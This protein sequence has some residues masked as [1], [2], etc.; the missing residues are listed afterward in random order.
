MQRFLAMF[1]LELK[2]ILLVPIVLIFGIFFPPFMFVFQ[3]ENLKK[4]SNSHFDP[5]TLIPMLTM[6]TIVILCLTSLPIALASDRQSKYFKRLYLAGVSPKQ[7]M[8]VHYVTQLFLGLFTMALLTV[9]AKVHYNV[10]IPYKYLPKFILILLL[11]HMMLYCI[12]VVI[13]NTS[14]DVKTVQTRALVIYFVFLFLG[15]LTYPISTMPDKFQKIAWCLPTTY[16]VELLKN[17]L[18]GKSLLANSFIFVVLGI[19][20]VASAGAFRIFRWE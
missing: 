11:L 14:S 17:I 16:G 20:V 2:K 12:G 18:A 15:D 9:I 19:L 5:L 3:M 10:N 6:L 1:T 13:G 8:L 7:Y 4:M